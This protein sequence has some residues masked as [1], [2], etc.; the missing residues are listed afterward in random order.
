MYLGF[1][2]PIDTLRPFS[3]ATTRIPSTLV[4]RSE[5]IQTAAR[6]MS[7]FEFTT[8]SDTKEEHMV[9]DSEGGW[10][11]Q[12]KLLYTWV[13]ASLLSLPEEIRQSW[14]EE[15]KRETQEQVSIRGGVGFCNGSKP[16][17]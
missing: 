16:E 8:R 3:I 9:D 6:L 4:S 5:V 7:T 17:F 13:S 1:S 15:M 11:S 10:L 2:G 14:D 12:F